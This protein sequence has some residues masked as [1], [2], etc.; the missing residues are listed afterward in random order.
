MQDF[1]VQSLIAS[2]ILTILVNVIPRLFPG[3]TKKAERTLHEKMEEA[4][5]EREDGTRPRM[6][7][8]FP[9]KTMLVIS[10]ILTVLV[11]VGAMWN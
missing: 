1:I 2:I 4:F 3:A 9:W 6:K 5:A 10:V 7:V 8:F 11:N